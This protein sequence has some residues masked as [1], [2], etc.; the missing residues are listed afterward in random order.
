MKNKLFPIGIGSGLAVIIVI[1]SIIQD[2][3]SL[4]ALDVYKRQF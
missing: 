1:Y 2:S 4:F 3:F